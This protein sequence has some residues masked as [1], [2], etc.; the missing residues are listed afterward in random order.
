MG[1]SGT[2]NSTGN[3]GN[4]NSGEYYGENYDNSVGGLYNFGY[5]KGYDDRCLAT[6]KK[7]NLIMQHVQ[8]PQNQIVDMLMDTKMLLPAW[9]SQRTKNEMNLI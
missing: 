6:L 9:R 3:E 4:S 8:F 2:G 5:D 7:R 1:N